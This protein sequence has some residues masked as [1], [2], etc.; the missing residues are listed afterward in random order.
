M[1]VNSDW[2]RWI[3]A[4][5]IYSQP[6][7]TL[8]MLEKAYL[9]GY[10][11]SSAGSC[12][13]FV[14]TGTEKTTAAIVSVMN[15]EKTI[16]SVLGQLN[17]IPLHEIIVVVNGSSDASFAIARNVSD[18]V[19]VRFP[20]PLGH[21]VGRTVGAKLSTA[22]ILLFI[23]GD[24]PILAEHL[25]PFIQAI[26]RGYDIALNNITPYLHRFNTW[27]GV[28]V[29]KKFLNVS[30]SRPDLQANSLTAVPHALSRKAVETIGC[31]NL[32][33]PPKALSIAVLR[34]LKICSPMS[35]DVITSNRLRRQNTGA[36]NPVSEMITGDHL[37]ALSLAMRHLGARLSFHDEIRK[38]LTEGGE[39]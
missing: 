26:D 39:R 17:R 11:L 21:D 38:R 25:S 29:I 22:D 13:N 35:V 31:Q 20:E 5:G 24:F 19:I 37:E 14:L 34:Q 36:A 1:R 27:D 8:Q 23:D 33:I 18:A 4:S 28:T 7:S 12:A 6:Y 15:E 30:L 16:A 9:R 32:Y 2:C 10:S 3:H